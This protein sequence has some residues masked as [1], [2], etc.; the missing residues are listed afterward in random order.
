MKGALPLNTIVIRPAIIIRK[1]GSP[2]IL[3]SKI[4]STFSVKSSL[5]LRDVFKVSAIIPLIFPYLF[6][7]KIVSISSSYLSSINFIYESK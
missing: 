2:K 6:S 5:D 3:L 1:I 4:L 7:A